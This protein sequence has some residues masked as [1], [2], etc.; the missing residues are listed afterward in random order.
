[1]IEFAR[2]RIRERKRERETFI[3]IEREENRRERE[4][5]RGRERERK[6]R[7]KKEIVFGMVSN[8]ASRADLFARLPSTAE[9]A[10]QMSRP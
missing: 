7:L 6:M 9:A 10:E 4:R 3:F 8:F 2:D 1:M 5:G